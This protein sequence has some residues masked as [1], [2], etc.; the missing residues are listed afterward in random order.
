MAWPAS[1]TLAAPSQPATGPGH[2]YGINSEATESAV[3]IFYVCQRCTA[4]CRWPGQ[5]RLTD[6]EITRLAAA[7]G[8]SEFDFIQRFTRL[9]Q[10]RR[11]LALQEKTGGECIFLA[12]HDCAVNAVKP[13][14]CRNFPNLWNFPGFAQACRAVPVEV[15]AE[16]FARRLSQIRT[17]GR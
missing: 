6:E 15:D 9:R 4:C 13:Q 5:V 1:S 10:D 11:G 14:Q 7:L 16:E 12:D 17:H 3:P 2:K 8:L